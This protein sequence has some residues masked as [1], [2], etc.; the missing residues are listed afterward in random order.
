MTEQKTT[1]TKEDIY[2]E[3]INPLMAEI[4]EICKTHK[5]AMVASFAI[6][7]DEDADLMCTSCLLT[8]EYE[9][10]PSQ[11]AAKRELYRR[12]DFLAMTI[13]SGG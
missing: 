13:T 1:P 11:L 4:L 5:I 7:S 9:P 12:P 6:P 3:Q 2:D 8:P 10:A